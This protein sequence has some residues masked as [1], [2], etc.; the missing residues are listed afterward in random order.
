[1]ETKGRPARDLEMGRRVKER[2]EGARSVLGTLPRDQI[3]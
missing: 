2:Q 3:T 1:M